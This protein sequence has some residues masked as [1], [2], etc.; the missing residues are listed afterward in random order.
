MNNDIKWSIGPNSIGCATHDPTGRFTITW[1]NLPSVH[2]AFIEPV[3]C[4]DF[5][6]YLQQINAL[7]LK[8]IHDAMP[9]TEETNFIPEHLMNIEGVIADLSPWL[10]LRLA[11]YLDRVEISLAHK[12]KA[13]ERQLIS[14]CMQ[15]DYMKTLASDLCHQISTCRTRLAQLKQ[16][17]VAPRYQRLQQVI[18]ITEKMAWVVKARNL[19]KT[20]LVDSDYQGALNLIK[21]LRVICNE[22]CNVN[23]LKHIIPELKQ[24]YKMIK[25]LQKKE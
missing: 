23:A 1:D 13:K 11:H 24:L 10:D 7:K 22:L 12:L 19:I 15:I 2:T 17:N 25:T 16:R 4:A 5:N 9:S 14:A 21:T 18:L 20:L 8:A 3:S 6:P